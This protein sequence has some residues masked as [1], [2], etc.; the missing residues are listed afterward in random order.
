[1]AVRKI[2]LN[3]A[4]SLDGF[5]EGPNGEVDWMTFSEETGIELNNFLNEIDTILYGRVSY[6][7]WGNYTPPED[8]LE[9][10]KNFYNRV[11]KM[12]KYVFSSTQNK[13]EGN[14]ILVQSNIEQTIKDLKDQPGKNIWLYGGAGL[15]TT[16]VNLDLVDEIRMAIMLIILGAGKPMFNDVKD[17]IE[18]KLIDVKKSSDGIVAVY[19]DRSN[20]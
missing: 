9:S 12:T 1:V 10:E 7:A 6:E 20:G 4:V 17:R 16:F 14:A 3:L 15:I 19:Y 2:I 18:L 13:F 8:S 11:N 5:I